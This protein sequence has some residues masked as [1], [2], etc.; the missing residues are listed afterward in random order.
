[1]L[2]ADA[3][4]DSR[5]GQLDEMIS[6]VCRLV[7]DYPVRGEAT[8]G[9][10]PAFVNLSEQQVRQGYEVHVVA[11]RGPGQP[12]EEVAGGVMVHRV[13][14]PFNLTA[15]RKV[16]RVTGTEPGWVVH[17]HATCG[18][19][20]VGMR[21]LRTMK[22]V[23]HSHGASRSRHAPI[24]LRSGEVEMNYSL[25]R[26]TY[27]MVRER[28]LWSSSDRVLTVS[29]A[30]LRDIVESYRVDKEKVR[31]VYNG[32]D[33][34][35]FRPRTD[36][37]VPGPLGPLEGKRII[38]YVGHFGVR[39]GVFFLIRAMKNVSKEVPDAHLVCVGGVPAWLGTRDYW[40]V[41]KREIETNGV[42]GRVTLLDK[43][44][45]RDLA[46]YYNRAEVFAL[47]SYYESLSKVTMEAMSCGVP[48]VAA[49]SGGV[50]ELVD[51]GGTG[52]LVPYGQVNAFADAL[53]S[54]LKDERTARAMGANGRAK[55]EKG[56]TWQA[57]ADRV[58]SAYDELN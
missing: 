37:E 46:A 28:T 42:S 51:D 45:N 6:K 30:L 24:R 52:R 12:E 21:K 22:L 1:M 47:A 5:Q 25:A 27:N 39:K 14:V 4:H 34:D 8:Y 32:V 48:V 56:F 55:I 40:G 11:G 26:T 43:V 7:W 13:R 35:A 29:Q 10:Q 20:L 23:A 50:P 19:F 16:Q 2:W 36:A 44:K 17:P 53:T 33:T 49:D 41:L 9:L 31:V 15:L 3:E 57:V 54:I 18:V 58:R 38:L